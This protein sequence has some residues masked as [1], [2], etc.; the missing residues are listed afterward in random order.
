MLKTPSSLAKVEVYEPSLT[1]FAGGVGVELHFFLCYLAGVR[2]LFLKVVCHP[3]C[4]LARESSLLEAFMIHVI[5]ILDL[6]AYSVLDLE[7]MSKTKTRELN[8]MPSLRYCGFDQL[9]FFPPFKVFLYFLIDT[10]HS[11]KLYLE[12]SEQHIHSILL[13]V[14]VLPSQDFD[15][16]CIEPKNQFG[17]VISL[18]IYLW[19]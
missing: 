4:P 12:H 2:L 17:E 8:A 15:V 6:L 5:C 16:N 9:V 3:L 11:F 1:S 14:K 19:T 7:Y 13:E 10:F 18:I